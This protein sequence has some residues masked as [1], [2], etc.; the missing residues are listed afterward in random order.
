MKVRHSLVPVVV[1][2]LTLVTS[3][4]PTDASAQSIPA[5]SV[6][7]AP[8]VAVGV[9]EGA[10]VYEFAGISSVRRLAGGLVV[11]ANG[12]PRELRLFDAKG[13]FLRRMGREGEG[14]GE[15]RGEL[16]LLPAGG[17]SILVL[18]QGRLRRM[19]FGLDGKLIV[20]Y[21][22]VPG[23][24]V[25]ASSVLSHR[26]FVRSNGL[27]VNGCVRPVLDALPMSGEPTLRD[28]FLDADGR[29]WV[30]PFGGSKW[31]V[32]GDNG[33]VV[34]TVQLPAGFELMQAGSDFIAGIGRLADDV[35]QAVVLRMV[36]PKPAGPRPACLQ[37][38]DAFPPPLT[39]QVALMK[40][41]FRRAAV[42]NEAARERFGHYVTTLDSLRLDA[43]AGTV[44]RVL[45]A[46]ENGW[47][48]ALFDTKSSLVC[49][50]AVGDATP[51]GW[52]DGVLRCGN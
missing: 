6:V 22:P 37:R 21:P 19:L 7:R 32:Y 33:K 18:D 28:L 5:W 23:G 39:P 20:E 42:A 49:I 51:P 27:P 3:I 9:R 10:M 38:T 2:C 45:R 46:T 16:H 26:T 35:E 31:T 48:A 47:A 50:M 11:V 29:S 25:L 52:T 41:T 43:P 40:T 15:F 17:D 34:G 1:G 14:P 30:R 4:V 13:K 44:Y 24:F 8:V 12:K 36:Q